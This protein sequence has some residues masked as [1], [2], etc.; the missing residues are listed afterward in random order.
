MEPVAC[1]TI[2]RKDLAIFLQRLDPLPDP[3]AGLE[4]YPVPAEI[5][6]EVLFRAYG[7]RDVWR[8]RVAD[9]GCGN[10][11]LAL[12]AA[13]LDASRVTAVDVD[14]EALEVARRNAAR[15]GLTVAFTHR[16]VRDFRE[17]V[18]TVFM[19]PPFGGQRKHADRPFLEAALRAA[20]VVYTFHNA[21][22]G[23][24]V[25][26]EV[27]RLGGVVQDRRTYK[28][29][30]PHLQPYHRKGIGEVEVYHYRIVKEDA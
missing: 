16:D 1:P 21:K 26:R 4:Q 19:N 15:L 6:A 2:K 27:A 18:D 23:P 5:A 14:K 24:Y 11:V 8:Q 7:H 29:P 10:G 3:K 25:E 9:L 22:T 20:S 28:F 17:R 12:G 30:L 13:H